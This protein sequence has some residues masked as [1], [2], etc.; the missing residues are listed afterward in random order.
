MPDRL[1]ITG[2]SQLV[3]LAGPQRPRSGPELEE[4]GIVT[5]GALLVQDGVVVAVG[6]RAELEPLALD[7]TVVDAAGRVVTP[8]LVDAHAHPVFG[9][10][11]CGEYDLRCRGS[12]YQEIAASGGGIKCTV[13][14]TREASE[15]ELVQNGKR[16]A[17]WL[18]RNGTTTVEAK[19]GY[20]LSLEDELKL[21]RAVRRLDAEIALTY[22]PTFLGAHSVPAEFQGRK[23]EYV[24]HVIEEMLPAV[25]REGLARYCD[26]FCEAAYFDLDDSRAVLGA[27]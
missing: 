18:L 9:G 12:S 19:S 4:L 3:T 5:D 27:A 16:F 23:A 21:L 1:F 15:D 17:S 24:R 8:G 11:R 6:P 13:R 25:A 22:V 10:N 7:A 20:G 14:A 2:C 26:V